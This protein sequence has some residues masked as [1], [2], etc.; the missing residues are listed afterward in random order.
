M[1]SVWLSKN[2]Y[3]KRARAVRIS[4]FPPISFYSCTLLQQLLSSVLE[5]QALWAAI[6]FTGTYTD[7]KEHAANFQKYKSTTK[8]TWV[9]EKQDVTALFG[10]VQTKLRTYGLREYVPPPGL[11]LAVGSFSSQSRCEWWWVLADDRRDI[12]F[13]HCLE[14][15]VGFGSET[16]QGYQCSDTRVRIRSFPILHD[17]L[18]AYIPRIKETLRKKFADVANDLEGRLRHT[19]SALAAIEG[20]L[21]VLFFFFPSLV[22]CV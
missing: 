12:G 14:C 5:I 3:E 9:T 19:S 2:D 11:A 10:N 6:K 21:E 18:Y 20:P 7:A 15:L 4:H 1:Q 8:R 13:G 17:L 16:I 22:R